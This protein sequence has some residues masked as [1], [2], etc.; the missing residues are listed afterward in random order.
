[1]IFE[2][3]SKASLNLKYL[4]HWNYDLTLKFEIGENK[5][6]DET[7]KFDFK[8]AHYLEYWT[9]CKPDADLIVYIIFG[10]QFTLF[11]NF[12]DRFG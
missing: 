11:P 9:Y 2:P 1:M 5:R 6:L 3:G 7:Y 4:P 12:I 10:N 8:L